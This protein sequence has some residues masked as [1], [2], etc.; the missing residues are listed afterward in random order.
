MSESQLCRTSRP[1]LSVRATDEPRQNVQ[2]RRQSR[3]L[4]YSPKP[5]LPPVLIFFF[6]HENQDLAEYNEKSM[7]TTKFRTALHEPSYKKAG[8]ASWQELRRATVT[9][10]FWCM[11]EKATNILWQSAV[12]WALLEE[13]FFFFSQGI[14][15]L[16]L[17]ENCFGSQEEIGAI[18]SQMAN[19]KSFRNNT[20]KSMLWLSYIREVFS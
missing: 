18:F 19:D 15:P 8:N 20:C 11:S 5:L 17:N 14:F 13:I 9:A 2:I 12:W 7:F 10:V 3:W 16:E 6:W 1:Q 4:K